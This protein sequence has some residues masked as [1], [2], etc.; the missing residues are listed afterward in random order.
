MVHQKVAA[1]V[2]GCFQ[3]SKSREGDPQAHEHPVVANAALL[4]DG[5]TGALD[6]R[7]IMQWAGAMKAHF[8]TTLCG[9]LRELGLDLEKEERNFTVM[10]VDKGLCDT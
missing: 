10:G 1:I 3:H 6:S 7:Q 2:V 4:H 5:T 8:R 9:E